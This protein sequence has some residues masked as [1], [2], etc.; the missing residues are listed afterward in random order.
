MQFSDGK[1]PFKNEII[2]HLQSLGI[3]WLLSNDFNRMSWIDMIQDILNL[4]SIVPQFEKHANPKIDQKIRDI[5]KCDGAQHNELMIDELNRVKPTYAVYSVSYLSC[6]C[7]IGTGHL[8]NMMTVCDAHADYYNN[9][10]DSMTVWESVF[11][12]SHEHAKNA[13][14]FRYP[15]ELNKN[16]DGSVLIDKDDYEASFQTALDNKELNLNVDKLDWRD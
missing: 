4:I 2:E 13:C 3:K 10:S 14:M 11:E 15:L 5:L 9:P 8:V 7:L 1:D 12:H 6:G 16:D